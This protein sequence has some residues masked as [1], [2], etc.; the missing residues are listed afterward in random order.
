VSRLFHPSVVCDA[1]TSGAT[2]ADDILRLDRDFRT[3]M[4]RVFAVDGEGLH[5]TGLLKVGKMGDPSG[6]GHP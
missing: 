6:S 4:S 5:K 1:S 3:V 2:S